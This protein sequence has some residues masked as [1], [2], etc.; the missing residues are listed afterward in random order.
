MSI[1]AV[2]CFAGPG[3]WDEGARMIGAHDGILGVEWDASACATAKAAGHSR[4]RA[5]VTLLDPRDYPAKG[6]I[7]SPSCT[8]FSAAGSGVGTKVLDLLA[9]GIR[10]IFAG[11]D[12]REELREAIYPTCL[13]ARQEANA[14]RK[15]EKRWSDERVEKAARSDAFTTCLV[16]EPARWIIGTPGLRWAALEQVKE[17][18]PLWDVYA[19]CL[20]ERGFSVW[21][22]KV[23]AADYGVPQTRVRSILTA[24]LDVICTRPPQTHAEDPTPS[25][26]G[27]L[28]HWVS[29]G[30]ALEWGEGDVL[31]MPAHT[32]SSG[33]AAT[34]GAEPFANANYRQRLA[35]AASKAASERG[36]WAVKDGEVPPVYVNGNQPNAARR[37]VHEPAP[38]VLFGHRSNDVRWVF[39]RPA[40]TIVGSFRPDVVS[41][42]GYR[43][44][45]SRQDAPGSVRVSVEEAGILQSFRADYPWKGSRTKRYE[46]VGNAVPPLLAAHVLASLGLGELPQEKA[47]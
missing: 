28:S 37:S 26:F 10:C 36:Q 19:E 9:D 23:C 4:V 43:T 15:P 40:T 38:T 2:D 20:R 31:D 13:E 46:Q 41:A 39:E 30:E 25:L 7:S 24:S 34:G 8:K 33:G 1:V 42:P 18:Q 14:K 12:C 22:G 16:L 29:L 17:V 44:E 11:E 5:D 45:I 6:H 47:A 21:T 3:G 35:D 27:T 32:V